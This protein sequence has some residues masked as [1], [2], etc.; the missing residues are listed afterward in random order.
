[1]LVV[2]ESISD[3]RSVGALFGLVTAAICLG[4]GTAPAFISSLFALSIDKQI[5][6][7]NLVWLIMVCLS[8]L[9]TLFSHFGL[10]KS[11]G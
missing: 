7:G 1:M 2:K 3:S 8:A 10:E 4:E 9:G 6:G 11:A 5:L